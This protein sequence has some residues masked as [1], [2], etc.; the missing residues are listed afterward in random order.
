[1]VDVCQVGM[2]VVF[3]FVC[4]GDRYIFFFVEVWI[5]LCVYIVVLKCGVVLCLFGNVLYWMFF[6]CVED[7]YL[8]LLV[9]IILVVIED[10]IVCV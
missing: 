7:E 1:M 8:D 3:E 6:Y 2:V 4:N 5:G 9:Q 10:V